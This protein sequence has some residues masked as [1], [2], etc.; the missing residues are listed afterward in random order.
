MSSICVMY[1][2][3]LRSVRNMTVA[4]RLAQNRAYSWSIHLDAPH[5]AP[6]SRIFQAPSDLAGNNEAEPVATVGD[7]NIIPHRALLSR[8]LGRCDLCSLFAVVA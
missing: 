7:G 6:P 5:R 2:Q 3:D 8:V 1:F 4:A